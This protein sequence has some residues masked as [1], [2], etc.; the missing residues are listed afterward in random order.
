MGP[1][2]ASFTAAKVEQKM[3]VQHLRDLTFTRD[4]VTPGYNKNSGKS[5]RISQEYLRDTLNGYVKLKIP[6]MP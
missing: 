1:C 5:I 6:W 3:R 2:G 4:K